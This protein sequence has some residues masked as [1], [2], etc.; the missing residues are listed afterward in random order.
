MFPN[1]IKNKKFIKM[2][3]KYKITLVV[4]ISTFI[5]NTQFISELRSQKLSESAEISLLTINPGEEL[6]LAFGHNSIRVKD[7]VNKIDWAYNY[8]TF[9]F[10]VPNY[11]VKFVAGKLNYMLSVYPSIALINSYKEENR[12]IREQTLN[13]TYQQKQDVF[14]FL[15]TNRLPQNKYYLYDFFFDNCATRVRDV[16]EDELKNDL[17]F[18][19]DYKDTL[20]HRDLLRP[21]LVEHHWS[22][23]GIAL[24]L[25][26]VIDD[27]TTL[28]ETMF[29]PDYLE[30]AAANATINIDGKKMP[31]VKKYEV[32]F[33]QT[34]VNTSV[35]KLFRPGFI[36][37]SVFTLALVLLAVEL[38]NKKMFLAFDF[39]YFL[40]IGLI[41]L[42]LFFAWFFTDHTAVVK[43]WNLLWAL[44]THFFI[45]FFFFLKNKPAFLK[46]YFLVSGAIAILFLPFW[47]II[48]QVFD[49]A[50]IPLL[51]TISVRSFYYWFYYK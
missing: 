43:N 37:W 6:Y 8:G 35:A 27:G 11:Y 29:L 3:Y 25:G 9:S 10:D 49:L 7:P 42:I 47:S 24:I 30:K 46:Y 50:F 44:P 45:V 22:R 31:F 19:A 4:F 51:L 41:G 14:K 33:I 15:Q 36:F 38:K 23:F 26:S 32:L 18:A 34:D 17:E 1:C 13:L 16:L 48:P 2:S 21:Y 20:T 28:A 5:I 39:V 12:T 40:F